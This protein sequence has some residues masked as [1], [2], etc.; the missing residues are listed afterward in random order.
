MSFRN[1]QGKTHELIAS[2]PQDA[3]PVWSISRHNV[4]QLSY[5]FSALRMFRNTWDAFAAC[6][7]KNAR[8]Y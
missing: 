1:F 3:S 7:T 2:E 6:T 4:E 8:C 5:I